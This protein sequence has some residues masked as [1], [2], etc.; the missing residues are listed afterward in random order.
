MFGDGNRWKV[1]KRN[2][3]NQNPTNLQ[4]FQYVLKTI[5]LLTYSHVHIFLPLALFFFNQEEALFFFPRGSFIF[6]PEIYVNVRILLKGVKRKLSRFKITLWHSPPSLS[7]IEMK[8]IESKQLAFKKI[9]IRETWQVF[10]C[11]RKDFPNGQGDR[12]QPH[13][14]F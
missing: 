2:S 14:L 8:K 5:I 3:E 1:R 4:T 12:A 9:P 13:F 11:L 6:Q 10:G 7:Q